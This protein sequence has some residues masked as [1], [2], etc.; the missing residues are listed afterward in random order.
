MAL[1]LVLEPVFECD[2]YPSSYAYRPGRRALDAV[3]EIAHFVNSGYEWVIR[4]RLES[5]FDQIQHRLVVAELRRRIIDPRPSPWAKRFSRLACSR[6][7]EH[8]SDSSRGHRNG[9]SSRRCSRTCPDRLR[10]PIPRAVGR[11]VALSAPQPLPA[12]QGPPHLPA[13]PLLRRLRAAGDGDTR[14]GRGTE[15]GSGRA[16][17][18]TRPQPLTAQDA[19]HARGPQLRPPRLPYRAEAEEARAGVRAPTPSR[20][21][22]CSFGRS[23]R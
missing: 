23:G 17:V 2:Q 10:P 9:A 7:W 22:R 20:P 8:S 21:Q 14:A 13:R 19:R 1:K 15:T 16:P 4:R 18:R 12:R 11:L 3:A 6:S 5:C